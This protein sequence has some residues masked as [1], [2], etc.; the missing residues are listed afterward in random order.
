MS[1]VEGLTGRRVGEKSE[2]ER[3]ARL[4]K[5]SAQGEINLPLQYSWRPNIASV[6]Q[7]VRVN[8]NFSDNIWRVSVREGETGKKVHF[9]IRHQ[10]KIVLVEDKSQLKGFGGVYTKPAFKDKSLESRIGSLW[11]VILQLQNRILVKNPRDC[12]TSQKS[13][14]MELVQCLRTERSEIGETK[15]RRLD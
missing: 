2:A 13:V 6:Q 11:G 8:H 9:G 5:V 1:R 7:G 4:K 12:P 14:W 10:P 3:K 15:R